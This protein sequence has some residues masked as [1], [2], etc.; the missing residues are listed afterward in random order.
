MPVIYLTT[1]D[2]FYKFTTNMKK[3][4]SGLLIFIGIAAKGQPVYSCKDT[5]N[6]PNTYQPC[7]KDYRPVCGCD[8]ITYRNACAAQYWGGL[9]AW[10]VD[11]LVCGNFH[12][13]FYPTAIDYF[14]AHF[15][16]FM[17]NPG[18]IVLYIFDAYGR[19]Q[20]EHLFYA[21][22]PNQ[23]I[24]DDGGG[25]G[26]EIPVQNFPRGIYCV[27]VVANGEK[28]FLKFGKVTEP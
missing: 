24:P 11:N 23:L 4:L 6:Q 22:Y 12:F 13:D 21:T 15:H 26:W 25:S 8:N 17:T 16:V 2:G 1:A 19:L 9:T 14:P 10:S 7:G 3:I 20:Y 28:Q 18:S 27:V 5:L